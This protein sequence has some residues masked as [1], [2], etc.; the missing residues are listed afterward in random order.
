MEMME[1]A[2]SVKHALLALLCGG[3]STTYQLKKDFDRTTNQT[4]PVNI[5][6]VSTTLQRL[7]RDGLVAGSDEPEDPGTSEWYL[8]DAGREEV[9][10]WWASPVSRERR[11]RDELVVKLALAVHVPGVDIAAVVQRQRSAMHQMLHDVT[12]ARRTVDPGDLA[13]RLVLDN[14][15]FATEAELRWLDVVEAEVAR[16]GRATATRGPVP[17]GGQTATDQATVEV[18]R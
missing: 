9:A 14:H 6:Q 5:G 13:A 3:P 18:A 4:W 2:V 7:V 12:R 11:G 17:A 16:A 8:T 15:I 1:V 10:R